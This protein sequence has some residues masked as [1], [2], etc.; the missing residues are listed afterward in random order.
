MKLRVCVDEEDE[1]NI[2]IESYCED[3]R[4]YRE[5]DKVSLVIG[6]DV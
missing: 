5:E 1:E 6:K 4:N 3:Y 2:F